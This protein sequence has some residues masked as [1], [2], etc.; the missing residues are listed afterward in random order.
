M[1][2]KL[3]G[4]VWEGCAFAGLILSRVAVMARLADYSNDEGVS[5]PA[6]ETLQ[7]QIG[8][9]SKTTV[10]SAIDELEREGWLVKR[11]RKRGRRNLSNLYIL[12]V[13]KL[14]L[15]ASAAKQHYR[16]EKKQ[17]SKT[18]PPNIEGS[19]VEGLNFDGSMVEG[20]MVEG[21]NFEGSMVDKSQPYNPPMVDPDP[22]L[23]SKQDPSNKKTV[24]QS[25]MA[26]DPQQ[27]DKLKIDYPKVL[28]A[29]HSILPEMPAVMDMTKDRQTKLRA[30]WKKYDLTLE[31]WSAYLRY[32][33][34]N[35][36]WMLED[37][38][39]ATAGTTWRRKNFDYLITEKCYLAVKE[40]RA[41]D[42]PKVPK[43]D[44]VTRQ[45]AFDRLIL[46]HGKAKNTVE[47]TALSM[48]GGL[49]RMNETSA[50]I[51]WN[52]IWAKALEQVSENEL[53]SLAS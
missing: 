21:S 11:E 8:A 31:R 23:T 10:S 3:H 30:L 39:N 2:S 19:T 38:P 12:N 42:L 35:C 33:S 41:N 37:R 16:K 50:R 53:R 25:P 44:T 18:T 14:E 36:R 40:K 4:L 22:S 43:I 6:V 5:W 26:T 47:K 24:G 17:P 27:V 48:A 52:G 29:Y 15:A 7:R 20:A 49:G 34:K 9:K 13:E 28:E 32:I 46:R 51:E 1:S 45:E